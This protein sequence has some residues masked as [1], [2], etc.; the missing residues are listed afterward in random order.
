MDRIHYAGDTV[1]TGTDIARALLEYAGALAATAK[2]ETVDIP[3]RRDD[4]SLGRVNFLIGPASQVLCESEPSDFDEVV[5][6]GLVAMLVRETA[7][8]RSANRVQPT[9]PEPDGYVADL[10]DL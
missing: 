7:K 10:D 5:D 4:G 9:E 8:L 2:S 6:V 3:C 1:L